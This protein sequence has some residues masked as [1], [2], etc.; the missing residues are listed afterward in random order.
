MWWCIIGLLQEIRDYLNKIIK[1]AAAVRIILFSSKGNKMKI[2]QSLPITAAP[3]NASGAPGTI[4]SII[5]WEVSNANLASI[6][7]AADGLS[8]NLVSLSAG[9]VI[10]TATAIANGAQISGTLSVTIDAP[11]TNFA[12]TIVLTP[13]TPVDLSTGPTAAKP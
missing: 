9:T 2:G 5:S 10:V 8:A 7:P 4:D 11:V 6:T 13:G 3:Q 1:S 12:T